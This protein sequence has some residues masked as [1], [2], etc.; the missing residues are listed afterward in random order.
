M[1]QLDDILGAVDAVYDAASGHVPWSKPLEDLAT[2]LNGVFCTLEIVDKTTGSLRSYASSSEPD[3]DA[4]YV[5]AFHAVNPRLR[6]PLLPGLIITDY[7]I[8]D[9]AELDHDPFYAE[10]LSSYGMRYFAGAPL[11][12]NSREL[13]SFSVQRTA[14]QGHMQNGELKAIKTLVPHLQRAAGIWDRLTA[15]Q[16]TVGDLSEAMDRLA[17]GI[18]LMDASG[19]LRHANLAANRIFSDADGLSFDGGTVRA[20]MPDDHVNLHRLIAEVSS[21]DR[22]ETHGPVEFAIKRP[23]GLPAYVVMA[24]PFVR[25]DREVCGGATVLLLI[26]DPANAPGPAQETLV[27]AFGLTPAE[28]LLALALARGATPSAYASLAGVKV[29]TVR[30]QLSAILRKLRIER[31]TDLVRV[32]ARLSGLEGPQQT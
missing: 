31:Q 9:E 30:S 4:D 10:F 16:K 32:V 19:N 2:L 3:M 20:A 13:V 11:K 18:V 28:A 26:R 25:R 24:M 21:P 14:G 6:T 15:M 8:M 7:D 23:S 1:G 22:L 12:H 27:Q 17:D 29:S 5:Q